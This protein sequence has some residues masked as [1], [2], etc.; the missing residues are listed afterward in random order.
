MAVVRCT[1]CNTDY[2]HYPNGGIVPRG[3]CGVKCFNDRRRMGRRFTGD[4]HGMDAEKAESIMIEVRQ[5]LRDDHHEID[6][7]NWHPD[8][9]RC[10]HLDARL[11]AALAEVV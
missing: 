4:M 2:F 3:Y 8:C 7:T 5:H 10:N 9:A 11:A 1:H 6:V